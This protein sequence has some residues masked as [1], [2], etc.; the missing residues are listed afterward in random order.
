MKQFFI[1]LTMIGSAI[2]TN[3]QTCH[4]GKLDP[5]VAISLRT[6][7]SDLP[8]S[9]TT[10]VEQMRDIKIKTPAFP[11]SDVR[12]IKITSDS[13]PIQ[14]YNPAHG[15]D[16]PII[17]SYH[18]GG[19]VTPVLPF[20]EYEFWRQASAFNAIVF[21]VDYR[22]AP[23]NKYPA[24]VNDAYNAF[25][26]IAENGQKFDGDTGRIVILGSSAGGNL[27]AVVCQKAKLESIVQKIKLQVLH[28]PST[29]DP[30]NFAKHPSYQQFASGY[31]LTKAF[32]QYY[33]R[34]YAPLENR[35]NPEIA[36]LNS[37]DL[38]GLPPAVVITAEFDP[39]RDEGA[40]YAKRLK[41]AGVP[42]WYKCFPGQIHC[43]LGLPPE[44][45]ELLE[46]DNLVITTMRL[47]FKRK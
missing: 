21:A 40:A 37:I 43:L 25:K 33:I 10:S 13:I 45:N 7:L 32:C 31:F 36:P 34:V 12:Y 47:L 46:A 2:I 17:I 24:A 4:S 44:A 15:K 38:S 16:L 28:C 1:S 42:V 6:E 11:Q 39:L 26:W 14:I 19:F 41:N 30:R 8:S 3:A 18:P 9:T 20:M 5:R 23:E 29:D 35:T 27:A 22:I